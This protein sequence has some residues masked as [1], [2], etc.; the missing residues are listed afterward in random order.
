MR[1]REAR[2]QLRSSVEEKKQ[3]ERAAALE[4]EELS[5]FLRKSARLRAKKVMEEH[6]NITLS[7]EDRDLFLTA[8]ENPPKP[9]KKLKEAMRKYR[10][11]I[12]K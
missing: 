8:L 4:G 11:N 2:I 6:Q 10:K 5:E 12:K 9:V 1:T 7:N 3:F